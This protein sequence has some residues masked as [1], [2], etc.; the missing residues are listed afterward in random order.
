MNDLHPKMSEALEKINSKQL[1]IRKASTVY[2][3]PRITLSNAK[4]NVYTAHKKGRPCVLSHSTEL[5]IAT[6]LRTVSDIGFAVGNSDAMMI[7]N[8]FLTQTKQTHL[9]KNREPLPSWLKA[10]L[11]RHD[12]SLRKAN[13]LPSLRAYSTDQR[14][15]ENW[16]DQDHK[17]YNDHGFADRPSD[18]WNTDETGFA[19]SPGKELVIGRKG[20][21][22][23]FF[24]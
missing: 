16:Y 19:C 8:E 17:I 24:K 10:F 22:N 11:T 21:L 14:V 20:T 23:S 6:M 5:K 4:N 12:L 15:F 9:F 3:I 2:G 18:I 7:I 1:S 13:N